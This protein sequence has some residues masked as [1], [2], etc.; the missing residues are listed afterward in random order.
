MAFQ[1]VVHLK[2]STGRP[3]RQGELRK[4]RCYPRNTSIWYLAKQVGRT[5]VLSHFYRSSSAH[6]DADNEKKVTI[7]LTY[8]TTRFHYA[9]MLCLEDRNRLDSVALLGSLVSRELLAGRRKS[10][11]Y[12]LFLRAPGLKRYG[13]DIL[14]STVH[15]RPVNSHTKVLKIP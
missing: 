1:K 3:K 14:M 2:C 8:V 13:A 15:V 11:L 6:G 12:R 10:G 9:R 7:S 5:S 4:P